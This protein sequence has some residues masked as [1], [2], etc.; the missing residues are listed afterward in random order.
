MNPESC[1]REATD[2]VSPF[3]DGLR[4]EGVQRVFSRVGLLADLNADDTPDKQA[5]S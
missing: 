2:S 5:R 4:Q 3:M 1:V